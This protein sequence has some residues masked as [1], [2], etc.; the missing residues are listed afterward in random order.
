MT[1]LGMIEAFRNEKLGDD[2]TIQEWHLLRHAWALLSGIHM[3]SNT[4]D[5]W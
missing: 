2:R 5:P 4:V 3:L 1:D